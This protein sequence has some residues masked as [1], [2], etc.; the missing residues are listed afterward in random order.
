[1]DK[2]LSFE[3]RKIQQQPMRKLVVP[4][5]GYSKLWV[6]HD[7]AWQAVIGM[8]PQVLANGERHG[9]TT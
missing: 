3:R 2:D 8:H 1:M 7:N 5:L 9:I 6:Q 4:R